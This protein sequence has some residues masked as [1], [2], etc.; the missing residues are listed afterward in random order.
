MHL[1]QIFL[2]L[3]LLAA[4]DCLAPS[5]AA[6]ITP[7]SPT[8]V[9]TLPVVV[10]RGT[11]PGPGLWKISRNG[12]VLWILGVTLPLPRHMQWQSDR[13]EKAIA[14]SQQ[15]LLSPTVKLKT[16]V[17]FFGKLFLLPALFRARRIPDGGTLQQK[18]SAQDY[19]RWL[20][21]KRAYVG[22]DR[23]IEHW[24]PIFA[25]LQLTRKAL[26]RH[27][28]SI[29]GGI[30]KSVERMARQHGVAVTPVAWTLVI[31]DPRA[32]IETFTQSGLNGTA[33]FHRTVQTLEARLPRFV[34][35]AN[36]WATGD[37][38]SL[39]RLPPD[40]AFEACV[41]A[42]TET[43]LAQQ[44]GMDDLASR[45]ESTWLTA[46]DRS[47]RAHA[48]TFA[49]MPMDQLLKRGGALDDLSAL[50]YTV[51]GPGESHAKPSG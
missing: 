45:I 25:A 6:E 9:A 16:D 49:V 34:I 12:H 41:A 50:G 36:A 47:M 2:Y 10:V 5:C 24:R 4:I 51:Q 27:D 17:G 19:A 1:P 46:V 22:H 32:A 23:G 42:I 7:V 40:P 30:D 11:Q 13:V 44:L 43:G 35:R 14:G 33:C 37:I 29:R 18:V 21:L 26:K 39:R 8:S 20:V 38:D 15:V 3:A 31:N 48:Q 28:L